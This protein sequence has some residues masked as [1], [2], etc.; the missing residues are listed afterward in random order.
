MAAALAPIADALSRPVH[1]SFNTSETSPKRQK[2]VQTVDR[3]QRNVLARDYASTLT[4]LMDL[5]SNIEKKIKEALENQ[6][7]ES[8]IDKLKTRLATVIDQI[9]SAERPGPEDIGD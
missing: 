1:L 2:S 9:E 3:L 8:K 6:E 5:E 7:E 4:T